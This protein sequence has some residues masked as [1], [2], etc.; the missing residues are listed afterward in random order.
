MKSTGTTYWNSPNTAASDESGF[1]AL[2]GGGRGGRD[3]DG[4]FGGIRYLAFFWSATDNFISA[5]RRDLSFTD[6]VVVRYG[7][8]KSDGASVRCLRD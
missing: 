2:P 7:Y 4:S 5:W 8:D 6:G 3:F 1:S